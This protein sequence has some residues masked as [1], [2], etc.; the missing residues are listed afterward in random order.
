MKALEQVSP[1]EHLI[2]FLSLTCE[3]CAT[4]EKEV[5]DIETVEF[6]KYWVFPANN[7]KI[8]LRPER[9]KIQEIPLLMDDDEIPTLPALYDPNTQ[10]MSFGV[11]GIMEYLETCGLLED[12]P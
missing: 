8:S 3:A 6:V 10:E 1:S 5:S 11:D 2:L 4:I 9:H 7:N 12:T